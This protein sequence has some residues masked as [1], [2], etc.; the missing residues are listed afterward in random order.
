VA[1]AH[2]PLTLQGAQPPNRDSLAPGGRLGPVI[3]RLLTG[4]FVQEVRFSDS[5]WLASVRGK[6]QPVFSQPTSSF[7][8]PKGTPICSTCLHFENS[9]INNMQNK[10]ANIV[11]LNRHCRPSLRWKTCLFHSTNL[12]PNPAIHEIP[13]LHPVERNYSVFG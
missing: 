2:V 8:A 3:S 7:V 11:M 13:L 6:P 4:A 1:I 12:L 10:G 5:G 9:T